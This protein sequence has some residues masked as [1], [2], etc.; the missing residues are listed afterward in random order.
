MSQEPCKHGGPKK[1]IRFRCP[2]HKRCE[3]KEIY[4]LNED[5]I[6]CASKHCVVE[7]QPSTGAAR[8]RNKHTGALMAQ[9]GPHEF[10]TDPDGAYRMKIHTFS[11]KSY[12]AKLFLEEYIEAHKA[13]IQKKLD[14][15][16][17]QLIKAFGG[18]Q[19]L[20]LDGK[21]LS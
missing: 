16:E 12:L 2:Y 1:C 7:T 13:T 10:V 8:L 18:G 9:F 6:K 5:A 14:E 17:E 20:G 4:Q 19:L 3:H 15:P 11:D 21:P